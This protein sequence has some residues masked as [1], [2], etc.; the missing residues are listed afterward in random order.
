M[1][2]HTCATFASNPCIAL[3]KAIEQDHDFTL[4]NLPECCKTFVEKRGKN[5][6]F[7]VADEE[8]EYPDLCDMRAQAKAMARALIDG[9]QD[10]QLLGYLSTAGDFGWIGS[11][12]EEEDYSCDAPS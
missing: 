6:K 10:F 2:Q 4:M 3:Q 5:R 1:P 11:S 7:L 12:S 8:R 9:G